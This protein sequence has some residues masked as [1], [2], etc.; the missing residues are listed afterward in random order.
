M[1]ENCVCSLSPW[2]PFEMVVGSWCAGFL[3]LG[4]ITIATLLMSTI[5]LMWLSFSFRI[6][7]IRGGEKREK[8]AH[9]M[10]VKRHGMCHQFRNNIHETNDEYEVYLVSSLPDKIKM[11]A[12]KRDRDS[13]FFSFVHISVFQWMNVRVLGPQVTSMTHGRSDKIN[14]RKKEALELRVDMKKRKKAHTAISSMNCS[15]QP[16]TRTDTWK[17]YWGAGTLGAVCFFSWAS[18]LK[19]GAHMLIGCIRIDF[20]CCVSASK[21]MH[22]VELFLWLRLRMVQKSSSE[23]VKQN[24]E[25][26]HN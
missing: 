1:R 22:S 24:S 26:I 23:G 25:K 15:S 2:C 9:R 3:F 14:D 16:T 7:Q 13:I 20:I 5:F 21:H 6:N 4:H 8:S 11:N 19:C 18:H 10:G 17:S 12:R